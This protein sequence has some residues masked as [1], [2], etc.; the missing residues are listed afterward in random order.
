[1]EVRTARPIEEHSLRP[2][3]CV[4]R[5]ELVWS[6]GIGKQQSPLTKRPSAFRSPFPVTPGD[7]SEGTKHRRTAYP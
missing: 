3:G 4:G 7:E 2:Q 6:I 1:M 5:G